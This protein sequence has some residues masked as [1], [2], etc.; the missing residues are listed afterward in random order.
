MFTSDC[1]AYTKLIVEVKPCNDQHNI[2]FMFKDTHVSLTVT[3]D[4]LKEIAATITDYF[5]KRDNEEF[6]KTIDV[7]EELVDRING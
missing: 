1:V 5:E 4:Q 7:V 6:N 3:E 2:G